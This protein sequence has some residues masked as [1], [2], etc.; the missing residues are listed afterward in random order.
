[1][2]S[3]AMQQGP[4][5]GWGSMRFLQVQPLPGQDATASRKPPRGFL[6]FSDGPSG[7]GGDGGG[8]PSIRGAS[9]GGLLAP[10]SGRQRRDPC[11]SGCPAG[12]R[13]RGRAWPP[14]TAGCAGPR[15]R[16]RRRPTSAE[17]SPGQQQHA[18]HDGADD[19]GVV[20]RGLRHLAVRV[21]AHHREV[22]ALLLKRRTTCSLSPPLSRLTRVVGRRPRDAVSPRS[23]LGGHEAPP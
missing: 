17:E 8:A 14:G 6:T 19:H 20:G 12:T 10:A 7:R 22:T 4:R 16:R 18:G 21:E 11:P 3:G 5:P 2:P 1:M 13:D 9:G 15:P 23:A